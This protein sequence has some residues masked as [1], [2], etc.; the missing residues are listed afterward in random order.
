MRV[1]NVR[2]CDT[3]LITPESS[4]PDE[5]Y[6]VGQVS[7]EQVWVL[8]GC[9]L[10][11]A[12][13]VVLARR[14]AARSSRELLAA[15]AEAHAL[16]ERIAVIEESVARSGTTTQVP[17]DDTQSYVITHLGEDGPYAAGAPVA[18]RIDGK[19]F[20][21]IVAR[22]SAIKAVGL[23]HGLR[24]AL[25]PEARNRIWFEMRREVKRARKERRADLKAALREFRAR[26]RADLAG[27][28]DER[29]DERQDEG[30]AA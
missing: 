19:L 8:A 3:G 29:P 22:E 4:L 26:E 5:G 27:R 11:L 1:K 15:R 30:D 20:A 25:A 23:A 28:E 9:A 2:Y 13:V 14:A 16:A 10:A 24:R 12:L 7:S 21:D 6:R 18:G 17:A